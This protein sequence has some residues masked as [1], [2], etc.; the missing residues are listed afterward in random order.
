LGL[1]A[2]IL[3]AYPLDG[4]QN[5]G[6]R[7][8]EAARRAV[9]GEIKGRAQPPGARLPTSYVDLRLLEHRDLDLP[10]PDPEFSAEIMALLGPNKDRYGIA[11]LDLSDIE[12]PRYADYRGDYRQN[13]G[14]VGKLVAALGLFQALAD[15]YPDDLEARTRVLH[16]TVVT[17]DGFIQSDHHTVRIWDPDTGVLTRRPLRIGDQ[18]SLWEFLD[19]MLSASSN[20]AASVVMQQAMLL[21]HYARDYPIPQ[22]EIE[23]FFSDTPKQTLA[24]LFVETFHEPVIRNGLDLEQLRQGS[25]FTWYGKRQV[26]GTT[27]Y[28][29]ARALTLLMLRLEQGRI[30]DVYSARQIKRLLYMTERRIRYASAPVLAD[31]AVY[32]KSGSLYKCKPEPDFVCRK[33]RGNVRNYMNSVAIIES[34]AGENRLFYITTLISNVLYKNSAVDHQSLATRI[35][36]LIEAAHPAPP[37]TAGTLPP[38]VTFGSML[39][40]Y[41]QEYADRLL[42]AGIQRHLMALGYPVGEVDGKSGAQTRA[43]IKRFQKDAG[44][45]LS[46]QPSR[47]LLIRLQEALNE[48]RQD[49]RERSDHAADRSSGS[50]TA[51]PLDPP[52]GPQ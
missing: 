11:V 8:V 34:P 7:R 45:V 32:F 27:S 41:E 19:W 43:A 23:R 33:Y 52:P 49:A 50:S 37:V 26:A 39:I 3:Y 31:S 17:A 28:G 30:V 1:F 44:E 5:T 6:I 4:Y 22:G 42:I 13:V 36:R 10:A 20:A 24:E 14:S 48:R 25:F 9:M 38:E 21:R 18:G 16:D 15:T 35:H 2:E 29:T 46:G 40:G 12:H 47:E 51:R